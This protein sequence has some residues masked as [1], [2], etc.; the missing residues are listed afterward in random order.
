MLFFNCKKGAVDDMYPDNNPD[1]I[2]QD[3]TV[4]GL[5]EVSPD[6]LD[7]TPTVDTTD[8]NTDSIILQK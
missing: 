7:E 5:E 3:S 8:Y 6:S 1:I 2:I 4:S